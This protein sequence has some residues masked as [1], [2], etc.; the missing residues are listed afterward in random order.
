LPEAGGLRDQLA[1]EMT[2]LSAAL[3]VYNA[4]RSWRVSDDWAGW[5]KRNPES[6]RM[7]SMVLRLRDAQ[8]CG[9]LID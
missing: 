8:A 4:V 2:R 3:N 6:W 7:V 5:A 9:E 1:G